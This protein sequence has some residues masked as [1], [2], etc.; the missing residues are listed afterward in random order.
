MA[1]TTFNDKRLVAAGGAKV[2]IHSDGMSYDS[3]AEL[4]ALARAPYERPRALK[5]GA[6]MGVAQAEKSDLQR[7]Y[8]QT[9]YGA[10]DLLSAAP[11]DT[12]DGPN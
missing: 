7:M 10:D 12:G 1:D 3:S 6:D 8:Q 9:P 11:K 5:D 2:A 4:E